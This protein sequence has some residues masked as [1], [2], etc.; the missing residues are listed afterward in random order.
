M[1]AKAEK[2]S[3]HKAAVSQVLPLAAPKPKLRKATRQRD[4][5]RSTELACHS[6]GHLGLSSLRRESGSMPR[7]RLLFLETPRIRADMPESEALG[8]GR[9]YLE[10]LCKLLTAQPQGL[11]CLFRGQTD[12]TVGDSKELICTE[13][14]VM[15]GMVIHACNR[16]REVKARESE[17]KASLS[18][19]V[20]IR[21]A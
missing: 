17:F 6:P 15:P 13:V 9:A 14:P 8:P 7:A 10:S 20:S 19:I 1:K 2:S 3:G 18:F 4:M 12:D 5:L 16:T 21:P 11:G